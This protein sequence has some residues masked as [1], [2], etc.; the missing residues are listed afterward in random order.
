VLLGYELGLNSVSGQQRELIQRKTS[1]LI[2]DIG[3]HAPSLNS[4]HQRF[5]EILKSY[6]QLKF[7]F[8]RQILFTQELSKALKIAGKPTSTPPMRNLIRR[9]EVDLIRAGMNISAEAM[10]RRLYRKLG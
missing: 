6:S 8:E 1:S 9:L 10:K 2:R 7:G 5:D 3:I 4:A